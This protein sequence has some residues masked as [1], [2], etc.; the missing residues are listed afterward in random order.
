MDKITIKY[1]NSRETLK[2]RFF[3]WDIKK[4]KIISSGLCC[5]G[6]CKSDLGT[7]VPK[8]FSNQINS[9]CSSLG[10]YQVG[11]RDLLSYSQYTK[12]FG[13]YKD[14]LIGLD[15]MNIDFHRIN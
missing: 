8:K 4:R 15:H 5:H 12:D 11:R 3:I 14:W 13:K 1:Q 6:D 9:Y 7:S 10:V 2:Y